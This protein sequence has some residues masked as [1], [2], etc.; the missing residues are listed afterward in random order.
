MRHH[1][2]VR[3]SVV[4]N[5]AV[6]NSAAHHPAVYPAPAASRLRLTRRGRVVLTSVA[7]LPL[8]AGAAVFA[9]NGGGAFAGGTAS[10]APFRY[11]TIQS[12]QSLW[13]VAESVAPTADPRDVIA[14]IVDLNRLESVDVRPG[15][16]L[17]IPAQYE[18]SQ[19]EPSQYGGASQ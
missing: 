14:G 7:A 17:A 13:R 6:H 8:V 3:N 16:R 10:S 4:Q 2:A 9:L 18:P 1:P 12:G 11:V 5:S 19:H 15:Q